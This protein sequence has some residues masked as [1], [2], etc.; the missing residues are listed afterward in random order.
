[1]KYFID[2]ALQQDIDRWKWKDHV[3]GVTSNPILLHRAGTTA[4]GFFIYNRDLFKNVFVQVTSQKDV[5]ELLAEDFNRRRIIFKVPL[6]L[7]SEFDGYKILQD[8]IF[9]GY[10]TCATIVYDIGQFDYACEI[11]AEYSIVLYAKNPNSLM[12]KQCCELKRKKE[13]KTKIVAAS[14]REAEQVLDCINDGADYATVPP[15][16]ME[17]VFCNKQANDDLNIFYKVD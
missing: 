9:K 2:T 13:Y 6:V 16:I 12:I 5:D 10:R 17:K 14:F 3:D 1:M 8:L 7:S 4:V 11:G 15:K